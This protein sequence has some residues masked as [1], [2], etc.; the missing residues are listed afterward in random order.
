MV[1]VIESLS[2]IPK[3]SEKAFVYLGENRGEGHKNLVTYKMSH[4]L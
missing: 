2:D 4:I 3:N 1:S